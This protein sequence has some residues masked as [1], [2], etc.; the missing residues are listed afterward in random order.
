[1]CHRLDDVFFSNPDLDGLTWI[2]F[3]LLAAPAPRGDVF[4]VNEHCW[5][6]TYQGISDMQSICDISGAKGFVW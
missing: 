1:M 3:R 2:A 5:A 4:C 6:Y